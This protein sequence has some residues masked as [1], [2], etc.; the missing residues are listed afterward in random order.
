VSAKAIK[1]HLSFTIKI[2]SH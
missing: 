1:Q 2:T